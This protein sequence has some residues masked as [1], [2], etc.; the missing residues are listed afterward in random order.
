MCEE[1][2]ALCEETNDLIPVGK[3][4]LCRK[5]LNKYRSGLTVTLTQTYP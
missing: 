1:R 4:Y 5:H 3:G 2:C